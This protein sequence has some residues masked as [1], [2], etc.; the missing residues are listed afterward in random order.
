M[1]SSST[2]SFQ[3]ILGAKLFCFYSDDMHNPS[4]LCS[5]Q[6]KIKFWFCRNFWRKFCAFCAVSIGKLLKILLWLQTVSLISC[7]S[8]EFSC[9][10][11]Q[12]ESFFESCHSCVCISEF[13]V[14][15]R[16]LG[17]RVPHGQSRPFGV[18]GILQNSGRRF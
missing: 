18:E 17:S 10:H 3:Q 14:D 8:S 6:L 9:L 4:L 1:G 5:N 11:L 12:F 15:E 13:V 2:F 16:I 7:Q